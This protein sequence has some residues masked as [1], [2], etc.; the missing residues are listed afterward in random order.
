MLLSQWVIPEKTHTPIMEGML[1][2]LMGEGLKALEI[3]MGGGL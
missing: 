2:N 3:L 1:E